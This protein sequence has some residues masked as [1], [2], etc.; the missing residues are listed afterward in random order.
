VYHLPEPIE[1]KNQ[2]F[3]FRSSYRQEGQRIFYQGELITKVIRI[4]PE[5]CASYQQWCF[6]MEKSFNRSVL[7]R[8]K[9]SG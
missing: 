6:E 2:Y 1:I 7:F 3:D 4:T 9:G 5:E 8:K